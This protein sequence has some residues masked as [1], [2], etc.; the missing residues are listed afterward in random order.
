MLRKTENYNIG[1]INIFYKIEI[2]IFSS[3]PYYLLIK[4]GDQMVQKI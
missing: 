1:S 3:L 2:S 4:S